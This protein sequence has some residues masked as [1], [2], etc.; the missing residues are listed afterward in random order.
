MKV[1]YTFL[2]KNLTQRRQ[3]AKKEMPGSHAPAW[4]PRTH[5]GMHSH[6]GAWEREKESTPWREVLERIKTAFD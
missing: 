4:E 1:V 2:K 3:G 5:Y 6:A